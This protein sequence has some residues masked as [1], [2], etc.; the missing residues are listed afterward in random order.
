[1]DG[2]GEQLLAGAGFAGD[3]HGHVRGRGSG[4]LP[5]HPQGRRA[6]AQKKGFHDAQALG[7][8]FQ[9]GQ[10][11]VQAVQ[12][13]ILFLPLKVGFQQ[14]RAQI[15]ERLRI[16]RRGTVPAKAQQQAAQ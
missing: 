13:Q 15:A 5:A 8:L 4:D 10:V 12:Q 7:A 11:L 3:Q 9:A 16:S 2:V 1:M 14:K 6:L